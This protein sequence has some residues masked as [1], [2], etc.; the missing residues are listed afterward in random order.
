MEAC[1]KKSAPL[2]LAVLVLSGRAVLTQIPQEP[3][4]APD[5]GTREFLTSIAVPPLPNAPFS[6]SVNTEW[7]RYLDNGATMTVRNRRLIAR[8]GQGRVFQERRWF[9]SERGPVESRLTRTEISDP[10]SRTI[11]YCD[12]SQRVCELRVY[13]APAAVAPP[14]AGASPNGKNSL[15]SENLGTQIVN[16]LEL[17]GTREIQTVSGAALGIDRP[18]KITKEFWYSR[19]LGL[20]VSTKRS[21]PRSGV[22]EFTVTDINESEPD[23][24]LFALPPN[25]RIVDYRTQAAAR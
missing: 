8:D 7:T 14:H 3:V 9:V 21:D 11:A 12:P 16:G 5:G 1:M 17:I 6:A 15:T 25:A 20:N 24:A 2:L 13:R 4:H 23:P 10:A 19:Q 22:E 18:L